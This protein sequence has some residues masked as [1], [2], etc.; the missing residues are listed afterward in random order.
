M[1]SLQFLGQRQHFRGFIPAAITRAEKGLVMLGV[2]VGLEHFC[3]DFWVRYVND[4]EREAQIV[5]EEWDNVQSGLLLFRI[6]IVNYMMRCISP[7]AS[8][9][10]EVISAAT[11]LMKRNV[12]RILGGSQLNDTTNE[13]D[14][15]WWLQAT[16]PAK[17]VDMSILDPSPNSSCV[18][19]GVGSGLFG[20]Y[21]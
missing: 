21:C 11:E 4:I 20:Q 8:F 9:T 5:C 15:I 10:G 1:S 14:D 17:M 3:R 19:P 16:L 12:R 2:P 18:V 7:D 13:N 6:C